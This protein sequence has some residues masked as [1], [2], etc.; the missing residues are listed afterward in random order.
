M[1]GLLTGTAIMAAVLGMVYLVLALAGAYFDREDESRKREFR[2]VT[3]LAEG[4]AFRVVARN[5][6]SSC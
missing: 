3:L 5:R 6:A 2:R 1:T 4:E